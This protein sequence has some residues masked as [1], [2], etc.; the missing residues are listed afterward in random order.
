MG[1]TKVYLAKPVPIPGKL[2]IPIISITP[3]MHMDM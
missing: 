2:S 1:N 3:K